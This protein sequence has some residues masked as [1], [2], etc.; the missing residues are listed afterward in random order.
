MYVGKNG[1]DEI[2]ELILFDATGD[3]YSYGMV[4]Q[5]ETKG[6][7]GSYT[8]DINGTTNSTMTSG[9]AF[10]MAYSGVPARFVMADNN[11]V[12]SIQSLTRIEDTVTKVTY[13]KLTAGNRDYPLS[14]RV[15][16]YKK[17]GNNKYTILPLSEIAGDINY[18]LTGYYD[19]KPE[20]GGRV[21]IILVTK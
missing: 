10:P 1:E 11:S 8:Y 4:L 7:S 17:D 5:A 12:D 3:M 21:R 2:T 13:N 15:I 9:K 18:T 6:A 14:D 19:K 20:L 16:V